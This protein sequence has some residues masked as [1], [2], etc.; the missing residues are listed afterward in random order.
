MFSC[1]N[2]VCGVFLVYILGRL[3]HMSGL[4][5]IDLWN[6]SSL[7]HCFAND[8]HIVHSLLNLES[9]NITKAVN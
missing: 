8:Q 3:E 9:D 1:E 6:T 2:D 5:G 4:A 7:V